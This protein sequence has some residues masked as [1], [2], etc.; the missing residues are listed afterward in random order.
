MNKTR[1]GWTDMSWNPVVGCSKVSPGCDHCYAEA[2]AIRFA[3]NYPKGFEVD[4][5]PERLEEPLRRKRPSM[6]FVNSMSDLFH[7]DI[8]EEYLRQI[9][10]VMVAADWHIFQVL[11]KRTHRMAHKIEQLELPVPDHIW[12]GTSVENQKF[13]ASR[14]PQLL[15][16]DCAVRFISAEPLLGSVDLTPWIDELQWVIVGGESEEGRRLMD[17]GWA[18][19]IRDI[20]AEHEVPLFYKQGNGPRPGMDLDLD[21]VRHE[22][23]PSSL[24]AQEAK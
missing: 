17:Y 23:F 3:E 10:E 12:L 14:I 13:A 20:C 22:E 9:W 8:P 4:L 24:R 11:T 21:G 1:I 18:R 19:Q 16:I 2:V 6:V 15:T 7:R 5:R